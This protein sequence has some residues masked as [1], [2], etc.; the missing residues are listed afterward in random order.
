[1]SCFQGDFYFSTHTQKQITTRA[2]RR[3]HRHHHH[4]QHN[5][6]IMEFKIHFQ[7]SFLFE[8]ANRRQNI[9]N[10]TKNERKM[11]EGSEGHIFFKATNLN[12]NDRT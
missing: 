8:R 1:M 5:K 2:T 12:S 11:K 6:Y 7:Q 9:K 4:H 10:S 3:R